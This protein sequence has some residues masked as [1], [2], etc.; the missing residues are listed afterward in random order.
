MIRGGGTYA[1]CR[2]R[3]WRVS[4]RVDGPEIALY[5]GPP[6]TSPTLRVSATEVTQIER[7]KCTA[8]WR[9]GRIFVGDEVSPGVVGF[10]SDDQALAEEEG[11]YG[12][13]YSGW[14]GRAAICELTDVQE[15]VTIPSRVRRVEA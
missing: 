4:G 8:T 2:G 15:M 5:D 6:S 13:T 12:D 14:R 9:N 7:V 3:T 11:L 10:Y 1:I